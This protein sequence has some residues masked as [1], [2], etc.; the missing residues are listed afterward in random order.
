M[1]SFSIAAGEY[2][3]E[4]A[5]VVSTQFFIDTA[6]LYDFGRKTVNDFWRNLENI[7]CRL[8]GSPQTW[9]HPKFA[10]IW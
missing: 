4:P 3:A 9:R 8:L 6:A 2:S 5:R 1:P 10:L 7:S